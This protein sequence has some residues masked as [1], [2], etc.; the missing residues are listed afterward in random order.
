L[1]AQAILIAALSGRAL[2]ASARRA[3]YLPFVADC[4]GD[5]DTVAL[6]GAVR[7]I[8]RA[9]TLPVA[10]D[11]LA[12]LDE[13]AKCANRAP[14]GVVLGSGFEG[15]PELIELCTKQFTVLGSSADAVRRTKDPATF[16][17]LLD[18]LD[19]VHPEIRLERP[20][21]SDG[22]LAKR[23]GGC[24]GIH[25]TACNIAN[26]N[27]ATYFQKFVAGTAASL[28]LVAGRKGPAIIGASR[29]W[30]AP[31]AQQSFRYGGAVGPIRLADFAAQATQTAAI[32]VVRALDLVGLVSVDFL[33]SDSGLPSLIEVNPRPGATLDV[34]DDAPGTLFSL[35]LDACLGNAESRPAPK[36]SP[37]AAAVLYADPGALRIGELAWPNWVADRPR[38]G[39]WIA[40]GSPICTIMASGDDAA[41]AEQL[42]RRR[43]R[44]LCQRLYTDQPAEELRL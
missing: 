2:A 44:A 7:V 28:L 23:I 39:T 12:A 37:R 36:A 35:H 10:G 33:V 24:G 26:S 38:N 34:F 5:C 40:A 19:I 14:L 29:Q 42:C 6:S 13:L 43:M 27:D 22:W 32:A 25:I 1:N 17:S 18:S 3:G 20:P 30:C 16:F 8:P 9:D 41:G 11:L 4:F 21:V 31:T 15:C